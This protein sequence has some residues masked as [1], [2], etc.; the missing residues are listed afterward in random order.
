M[1]GQPDIL[2]N[3]PEIEVWPHGL[4]RARDMARAS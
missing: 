4:L 2:I 3:T 1:R